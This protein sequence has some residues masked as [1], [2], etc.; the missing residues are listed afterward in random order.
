MIKFLSYFLFPILAFAQTGR[1]VEADLFK[2]TSA[3]QDYTKNGS[4]RN[5]TL[6]VTMSDVANTIA[7]NT[8]PG[9]DNGTACVI[10]LDGTGDTATFDTNNMSG[11]DH[12]KNCEIN[13]TYFGDGT[14]YYAYA[15]NVDGFTTP[16][17]AL[18][19]ATVPTS[20][21][22]IVLPCGGTYG[23]ANQ[24]APKL[25]L[26][27][28]S[29]SASGLRIARVTSTRATSIGQ[30][31][32]ITDP[33]SYT[34]T[35]T[36]FGTVTN[37]LVKYHFEGKYLVAEGTFTPGTATATPGKISLPA[38]LTIDTTSISTANSLVGEF[39]YNGDLTNTLV[40]TLIAAPATATDGV[41]LARRFGTNSDTPLTLQNANVLIGTSAASFRFKVPIQGRSANQSAAAANQADYGWTLYTPTFTGFGTVS[42]SSCWHSKVS[43]NLLLQCNFTVGTPTS[44]EARVSLPNNLV[45]DPVIIPSL[46]RVGGGARNVSNA[47]A[48]IILAEPSV[49]YVTFGVGASGVQALGKQLGNV[50]TS[51]GNIYS[52]EARI[53]IQGWTPNQRNPTLI[54]SVS[55]DTSNTEK[56]ERIKYYTTSWGTICSSSPCTT[57]KSDASMTVTRSG[58]GAYS[59]NFPSGKYSATP[60]CTVIAFSVTAPPVPIVQST[61]SAT[62][63]TFTTQSSTTGANLDTYGEITC[64]GPR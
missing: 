29:G 50:V 46:A 52:F 45:V 31:S 60:S 6:N 19:N 15:V 55:S 44:T 24:T 2:G 51:T 64:M 1:L 59:V 43:Q 12:N 22:Y 21:D 34:P 9:L 16:K 5:N 42:A 37:I 47:E 48:Q 40:Y 38:G 53:P 26:E 61:Q 58:T 63:W 27:A 25:R 32:I 7:Q 8:S 18:K 14:N 10:G 57:V 4:C 20:G 23:S 54:G 35:F 62:A 3:Y 28:I 11:A 49:S 41:Y 56:V 17:V 13:F 39:S 33:V 36:G 30:F